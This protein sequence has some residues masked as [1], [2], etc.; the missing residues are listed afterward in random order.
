[1]R[2]RL[3]QH[4]SRSYQAWNHIAT[5]FWLVWM[6]RLGELPC[7][8]ANNTHGFTQLRWSSC[9]TQRNTTGS[10]ILVEVY[11]CRFSA[12]RLNPEGKYNQQVLRKSI[13]GVG[14]DRDDICGLV[15]LG[16]G[17]RWN[18]LKQST[19][20]VCCCLFLIAFQLGFM[21]RSL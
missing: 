21:F 8:V 18:F 2:I 4:R 16:G 14:N 9:C 10:S 13:M 20:V 15:F 1:M 12:C 17:K 19:L 11:S 7:W 5:S 3:L 6:N